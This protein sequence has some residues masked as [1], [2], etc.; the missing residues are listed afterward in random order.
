MDKCN[1]CGTGLKKEDN[2]NTLAFPQHGDTY[3]VEMVPMGYRC[4]HCNHVHTS[5]AQYYEEA[6]GPNGQVPYRTFPTSSPLMHTILL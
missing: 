3:T 4:P 5:D 2:I 1:V 6:C